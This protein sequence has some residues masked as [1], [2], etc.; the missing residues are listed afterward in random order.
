MDT[1]QREAL[2]RALASG[3]AF[4]GMREQKKA[5]MSIVMQRIEQMIASL[6]SSNPFIEKVVSYLKINSISDGSSWSTCSALLEIN[7]SAFQVLACLMSC[8]FMEVEAPSTFVLHASHG[9]LLKKMRSL[10]PMLLHTE[11][12]TL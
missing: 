11:D 10:S 6:Q 5:V 12:V 3:F 1:V 9:A 8:E 2:L 7:R 4:R